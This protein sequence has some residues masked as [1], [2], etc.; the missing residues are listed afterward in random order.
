MS[1]F[2]ISLHF[3]LVFLLLLP[4]T[5]C[6]L[7]S[8]IWIWNTLKRIITVFPSSFFMTFNSGPSYL[9]YMQTFAH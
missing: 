5:F 1:I 3:Q 6:L 8:P 2:S 7:C 4:M 9:E